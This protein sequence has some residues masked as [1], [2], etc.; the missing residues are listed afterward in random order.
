MI[1]D[2]QMQKRFRKHL[3]FSTKEFEK[4]FVA[5]EVINPQAENFF[6]TWGIN[7]YNLEALIK[8]QSDW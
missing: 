3:T 7:R 8:N 1:K 5:Y 6:I 4:D 2:Q